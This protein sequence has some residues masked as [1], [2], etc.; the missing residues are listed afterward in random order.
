MSGFHLLNGSCAWLIPN[1][2]ANYEEVA[3]YVAAL[4]CEHR[5][6]RV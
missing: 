2:I 1:K 3:A 4:P 5:T 6:V